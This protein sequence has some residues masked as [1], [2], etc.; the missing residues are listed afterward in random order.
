MEKPHGGEAPQRCPTTF[1]QTDA[2]TFKELVQRLTGPHK[3]PPDAASFAPAKVAGLK[4]LHERRRGSRLKLPVM[5]PAVGPAVLSPSLMTA[6]VSPSTGFAGLG[7]CDELNEEEEE[8]EKAIKE[9]RFYLH[10]SPRSRSQNA[11]PELL[12]L[13]PLT[14]P[15]PHDH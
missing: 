2:A 3:Q 12:P 10:P 8:E 11:E 7:I 1:V 5:K 6:L 4:R 14:S 13:F 9:R 15:K